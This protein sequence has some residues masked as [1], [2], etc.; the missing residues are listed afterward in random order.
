[1]TAE[2]RALM[3]LRQYFESKY[4]IGQSGMRRSI[5]PNISRRLMMTRLTQ[6]LIMPTGHRIKH[7]LA[8]D[9]L[10]LDE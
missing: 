8:F 5:M 6:A 4:D 10:L 9:A 3:K 2:Y 7:E 1:M